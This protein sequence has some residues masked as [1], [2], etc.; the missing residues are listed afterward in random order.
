MQCL[1]WGSS[2]RLG[3][4]Q[5]LAGTSREVPYW[6][7]QRKANAVMPAESLHWIQ[8]ER[9]VDSIGPV[10][11]FV[12]LL[13]NR[14]LSSSAMNCHVPEICSDV[15]FEE[16]L[17]FNH[18]LLKH[19]LQGAR[20]QHP[21][22]SGVAGGSRHPFRRAVK[23]VGQCPF[24]SF[25][26]FFQSACSHL[27]IPPSTSDFSQQP[28][29]LL[30]RPPHD[31]LGQNQLYSATLVNLCLYELTICLLFLNWPIAEESGEF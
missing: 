15:W 25:Y 11:S 22:I 16:R 13:L 1:T 17:V 7:N 20:C 5:G 4:W 14:S 12:Q 2:S 31:I 24:F 30:V 26:Q 10:V 23:A 27:Q 29:A 21:V 28:G 19:F 6:V 9:R 3:P 8:K 18:P